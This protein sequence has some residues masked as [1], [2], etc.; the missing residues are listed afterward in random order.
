MSNVVTQLVR[1]GAPGATERLFYVSIPAEG[2]RMMNPQRG[3]PAFLV[4]QVKYFSMRVRFTP[5][6]DAAARRAMSCHLTQFSD[7]VVQ[8]VSTAQSQALNGTLPLAPFLAS[9]SGTDLF[10]SPR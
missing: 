3:E 7:D 4:P 8:R 10:N 2:V 9:D 1:A 5:A 6:D